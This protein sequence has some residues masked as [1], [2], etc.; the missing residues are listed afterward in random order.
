MMKR[1]E[2]LTRQELSLYEMEISEFYYKSYPGT[3]DIYLK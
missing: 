1:F 2:A 3:I